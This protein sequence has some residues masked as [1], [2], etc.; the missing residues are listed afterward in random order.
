MRA[1]WTAALLGA[2][3]ALAGCTTTVRQ[4]PDFRA[5]R[6]Q[7]AT[8]AVMPP[9]VSFVRRVFKGDD[10]PLGAEAEAA[11]SRLPGLIGAALT[12]RGFTVKPALLD[13]E[14]FT[15]DPEL[16]YQTT[17]MQSRFANAGRWLRPFAELRRKDAEGTR[18]S[19]G[20]DVNR[21]AD[22]AQVDALVF[23]QMAGWKKSGG[24]IAKDVAVSVLLLG[25]VLYHTQTGGLEIGLVDGTTGEVLWA[26]SVLVSGRDFADAALPGMVRQVFDGFPRQ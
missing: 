5:R 21:F 17:L 3:L 9:D 14:H 1:R 2:A 13:E 12:G 11:R 23:A 15:D 4:H 6:P 25:N 20:P 24:E 8:V 18:V 19:L 7:I 22:H 26:N 10:E 16:R